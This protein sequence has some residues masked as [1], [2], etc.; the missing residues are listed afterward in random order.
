VSL[1]R[2]KAGLPKA[3]NFTA[4][5]AHCIAKGPKLTSAAVEP[6][7][8]PT[9]PGGLQGRIEEGLRLA[10][11]AQAACKRA[12]RRIQG[13]PRTVTEGPNL[14]PTLIQV[15]AAFSRVDGE[16]LEEELDSSLGFLRYDYPDAVYSE[17]RELFRNALQQNQDLD[18]M[19]Q[20]LAG[21]ISEERKI[22]LGV[23][24]Y[25]LIARAGLKSEAVVAYYEFM[26]RLGMAS[27]AIDI[28]YQLNADE[29]A[30]TSIYSSGTSPLEMVSFGHRDAT[31]VVLAGFSIDERLNTYRFGDLVII[32]NLS[33]RTL[34]VQGR[35][36]EPGSFARLYPGQRVIVDDVVLTYADLIFYFNAKK[37]VTMP[38]IFVAVSEDDEVTL[39]KNR[40]RESCLQVAFGLRVSVKALKDV[41]AIL[42]GVR[43]TARREVVAT[44]EDKIIFHNDSELELDYLRLRARSYGGR[45]QLKPSKSEYLVSNNPGLLEEDD[46]L[47]AP[48]SGGDVLLRISCDYEKKV[49]RMEVL[50]ADRPILVHGMPVRNSCPLADGDTIRVDTGQVLRCNFSERLIEEEKNLIRTLDVRDLV[51]RFSNSMV[52]IDGVSFT[53]ERGEMVCVMGASGCGKS[54]L[55]RGLSGQFPPAQGEVLFN[56]RNLY[57]NYE[58]LR[59]YVTYIPQYDA[60][61]EHL[62]IEENLEFAAAIRAPHLTRRERLRR[63]DV[64][65]AELGLNER[66]NSVVGTS[67]QKILSGGERKRL[68]IGLDMVSSADIFLFDEPTSGLSSKDSEHIMDII[69][70]MSHN[71][72]VLVTIHQPTSRIFQMFHK[73]IVLDRGGKL[74]F[75]GTPEETLHYFAEAE[76]HQ[77][78]TSAAGGCDT[79]GATRPEFIFD[80]LETPLRDLGGDIILEENNRGQ[81]VAAR[82]YSP[83]YWRDKYESYRLMKEVRQP[84]TPREQPPAPPSD[85]RRRERLRPREHCRQFTILLRRAFLSKLRNRANLL[86]TVLEAPLLAFLTGMV[87]RYSES[88]VYDFASAF[89]IPTYL[90]LA[91]VVAMFLGLTNS[92]DDIIHDRAVLMRERNLNVNIGYYVTAKVLTLGFF[93]IIQCALFALIG[94]AL[95][96]LR[97]GFWIL[98]TAMFLTA[99]NGAAIGLV[100]S[101]LVAQSK[102]GILI[103]PVILIPQIILSGAL[104]KYE[105]MNRN[106]D[107]IHA[108]HQWVNRHPDSAMPARSDLQVPLICEIMPT[109]WS[110]E[111]LV[112][113]QAK[114]NPLTQRQEKIQ[115]MIND[116]VRQRSPSAGEEERLEDL[117]DTLALLSGLEGANPRELRAAFRRIDDII[118]G[119]PFKLARFSKLGTGLT[120]EQVYVNQKITDLVSKAE[121]EQSDYREDRHLN[122]F[123]GPVKEYLGIR[124]GLLWFNAAVLIT[125]TLALFVVLGIILRHQIRMRFS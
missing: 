26:S 75:F 98:F 55:L 29:K 84:A 116:L 59:K 105:E 40:S 41:D 12:L 65:L 94:N 30:D 64:K 58:V 102:T 112:Y 49:G 115:S 60:F 77:S 63:I 91:L 79:C 10:A 100:I 54:T 16:L 19:A 80:V 109:R 15:L 70:D 125:S 57:A 66:R 22:L 72:I 11:R 117:K 61:D 42:N 73:A 69:R 8:S 121:M 43:L 20:K 86:T 90:F 24:L 44:L 6:A 50:Q 47:L 56:G 37:N 107:F 68:N 14:L 110:Y 17:L 2:I 74:V 67:N 97:D 51:C 62:T 35:A 18:D 45:F 36:L 33:G 71:K 13:R 120:A 82:R 92:V 32:K 1:Q 53:V 39:E 52:A 118:G 38:E 85:P 23:Q 5:A 106:L 124:V 123:F 114:L 76:S 83:D 25:D 103:I 46:I 4:V 34:I 48:G 93:A 108:I 3:V 113:A 88:S 9:N 28:V 111:A 95:L 21:R 87:L 81:L 31:D 119:D 122:V 99:A 101:A 89:H 78:T 96:S 104:I 7:S 27:Q